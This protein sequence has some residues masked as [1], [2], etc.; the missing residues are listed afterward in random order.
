MDVFIEI[1][2]SISVNCTTYCISYSLT[3]SCVNNL[4][5][6]LHCVLYFSKFYHDCQLGC[7]DLITIISSHQIVYQFLMGIFW[8]DCLKSQLFIKPRL[9]VLLQATSLSG[10]V[11][12]NYV[13]KPTNIFIVYYIRITQ[14]KSEISQL[15]IIYWPNLKP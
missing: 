2:I 11:K 6:P 13:Y 8:G 7:L 4:G 15:F 14:D 5:K 3:C 9:G 12:Y 1:Y 10:L